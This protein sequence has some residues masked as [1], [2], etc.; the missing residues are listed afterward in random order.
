MKLPLVLVLVLL[1]TAAG[2]ATTHPVDR[3]NPY[4]S[5]SCATQAHLAWLEAQ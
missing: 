2:C 1:F 5:R 3:C 4:S